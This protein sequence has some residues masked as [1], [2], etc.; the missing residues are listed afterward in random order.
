MYWK[1]SRSLSNGLMNCF[2]IHNLIF[3]DGRMILSLL[4]N[5]FF[6]TLASERSKKF[7]NQ[8]LVLNE[9]VDQVKN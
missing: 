7:K 6:I 5:G 8:H 4:N 1:Q 2:I 9:V 3:N